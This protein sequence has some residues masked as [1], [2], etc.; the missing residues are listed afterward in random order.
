MALISVTA[1][2]LVTINSLSLK[3]SMQPHPINFNL[4][5]PPT[6]R[7]HGL[8]C[9]RLKKDGMVPVATK[10][11]SCPCMRS[12]HTGALAGCAR[13]PSCTHHPSMPSE[14]SGLRNEPAT[15]QHS[16]GDVRPVMHNL[17][18]FQVRSFAKKTLSSMPRIIIVNNNSHE[19]K[20][21][22]TFPL[23]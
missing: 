22:K 16:P 11:A 19:G 21:S 12:T 20:L 13:G 23:L 3:F 10:T 8:W 4:S 2:W 9:A 15:W 18:S 1:D 5:S 14:T 17:S 7:L 6:Y